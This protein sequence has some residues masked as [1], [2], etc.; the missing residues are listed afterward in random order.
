MNSCLIFCQYYS[1]T[2]AICDLANDF[3]TKFNFL[4]LHLTLT[5]FSLK[6]YVKISILLI[7]CLSEEV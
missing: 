6:F 5:G 3:K 7:T 1:N 4:T 2:M